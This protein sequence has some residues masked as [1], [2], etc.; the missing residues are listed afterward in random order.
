MSIFFAKQYKIKPILYYEKKNIK[1]RL[2][3]SIFQVTTHSSPGQHD[4]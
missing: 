4:E 3:K 1:T 2:I